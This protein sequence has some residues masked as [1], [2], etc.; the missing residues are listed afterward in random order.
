MEQLPRL[1]AQ[2]SSLQDLRDLVRALRALSAS[3]AQEA[4]D[5]LSGIRRYAS[6][7]EDAISEGAALVP[8][9]GVMP[10]LF[11]PPRP[12]ALIVVCSEHGFVGAYNERL[13]NRAAAAREQGQALLLVGQ[14]GATLAAER[15]LEVAWNFSMATH[16]GGVL[17]TTRRVV[18]ALADVTTA[19]VLY[20]CHRR[21]GDPDI[22]LQR[23][24]P[25]EPSLLTGSRRRCP[26]L[27]H[28][29]PEAL[30]RRLAREYLFAEITRALMESLAS[31]N[32]ARLR[33]MEAA[34]HNIG[35]RLEKFRRRERTLRQET[36]TT[37]LLDVVIG[38]EAVRL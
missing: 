2:I 9:L 20:G 22:E 27:H 4:Q 29:K 34:D 37:E 38:S 21:G 18:A 15:G 6:V 1:Q 28:L 36:I 23:I 13:L 12:P 31:E 24:L 32:S 26:P 35:E 16:V 17:G 10:D 7:V 14:R 25:L 30:L 19:D 8:E 3:H 5:A 11:G 33:A